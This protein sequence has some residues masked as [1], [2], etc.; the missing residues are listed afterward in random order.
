[1]LNKVQVC[2]IGMP[3]TATRSLVAA[4][5]IL[6]YKSSHGLGFCKTG[7]NEYDD[8]IYDVEYPKTMSLNVTSKI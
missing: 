3:R 1:M 8:E 2:E 6:G 4:M 5:D 7:K